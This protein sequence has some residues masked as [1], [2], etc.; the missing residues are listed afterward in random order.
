MPT[1]ELM[2]AA[3]VDMMMN[4]LIFLIT[5]YGTDPIEIEPSPELVLPR[6]S[7]ERPIQAAPVVRV[8]TRQ[9]ALGST[10]IAAL[11]D[12]PDGPALPA[13][14]VE[15]GSLPDLARELETLATATPLPDDG[16]TRRIDIQCD[17]RISWDILGP[18]IETAGRA[19]F[20]DYRFIVRS[21]TADA[22]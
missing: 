3:M 17:K 6:S 15:R 20:G 21:S 19:G 14:A 4:L 18:V 1:G 22:R 16:Q 13:G 5:L 2:L 8:T 9:V 11:I 10:V 12:G 7:A